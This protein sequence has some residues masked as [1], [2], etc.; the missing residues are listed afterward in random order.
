MRATAHRF[1]LV[2]LLVALAA[3]H[4]EP[5]SLEAPLTMELTSVFADGEPIP[6]V[7]T[8]DGD[9]SSPPLRI[10]GIPEDARSL[11]LVV[12]DPDAPGGTFDH[13]VAY[14]I[15]PVGEIPEDVGE[16][17]VS[18]RNSAGELGYVGPCPPSGIHRYFFR[19]YALDTRLGLEEG[20]TKSQ[21]L[22][23]ARD[24]VLAEATLMGTYS[25]DG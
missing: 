19:V 13:W 8:C 15:E 4:E 21:V 22:D 2:L 11:I 14:D 1:R 20:A 23:A 9:E 24:H 12:D 17:G 6:A 10:E 7:Y 25:R 3:C 5:D 18:G 16:I